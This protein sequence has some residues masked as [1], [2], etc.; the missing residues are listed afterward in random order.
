MTTRNRSDIDDQLGLRSLTARSVMASALLGTHPPVLPTRVL[1]AAA[2]LFGVTSTAAR[3]ALSRMAAAG[4]VV[5]EG[6]AYRLIGAPLL[7]R[8]QR[9][10]VGRAGVRLPWTGRWLLVIIEPGARSAAER[11]DRRAGLARARLG[12]IRD[13]AW[14]RPD[15]LGP[16]GIGDGLDVI[17]G[18]FEPDHPMPVGELWDLDGWSQRAAGLAAEAAT[19]TPRLEAGDESS[20]ARGFVV[21][22]AVL[23]LFQHDPLLPDELL[24]PA[25]PGATIRA[26]YERFD[27]AYR[28]LLRSWFAVQ[29]R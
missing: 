2:D 1:V 28:R 29:R 18:R 15:N 26:T 27:V 9:Q 5:A 10:A 7:G 23:R 21:S 25:W 6:G 4:E 16:L 19:L 3:T 12:E 13:G 14:G 11:A 17:V 20:L 8:Q 22:A 24:P